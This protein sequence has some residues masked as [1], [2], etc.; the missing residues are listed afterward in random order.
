MG[1]TAH[2]AIIVTSWDTALLAAA[3]GKAMSLNRHVSL[4]I[5]GG[6]NNIASFMVAPDGS[7]DGWE[8]SDVGDTGRA[9]FMDWLDEQAYEDGSTSLAWVEVEFNEL[10]EPEDD[11]ARVTR[12][13]WSN[14]KEEDDGQEES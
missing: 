9:R 7:K 12:H 10:S 13:A 8:E 14:K 3:H 6:V 4:I 11:G 2:H 1:Y 5:V